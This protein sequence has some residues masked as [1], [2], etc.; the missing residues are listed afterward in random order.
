[1]N[2]AGLTL[3][4][5]DKRDVERD[6]LAH[7]WERLEGSV[8]RLGRFWDPP[9][10][11]PSSVRV[12]G[13][14]AFCLVLKQTLGLELC[15]PSDDLIFAV[16]PRHLLRAVWRRTLGD[17]VDLKYPAFCKPTVPKLF[18]ARV[19]ADGAELAAECLGL[20]RQTVILVS[21]PVSFVAEARCFV[22]DGAVL[23]CAIYEGEARVAAAAA[24]VADLLQDVPVP[25]AIVV[26][27][28]LIPERGWALV[29]F[30]AVWGAGLNGC[31]AELVW[32]CVAAASGGRPC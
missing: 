32:P 20:D 25:R 30:N 29:E 22:L 12:Y 21:E 15:S 10:L 1:M 6:A 5:P 31:S 28:G 8:M 17:M 26:D 19:Y 11:D 7:V 18:P 3:L 2:A 4:L 9:A 13:N 23:D 27:M 14:E 24:A 16:P